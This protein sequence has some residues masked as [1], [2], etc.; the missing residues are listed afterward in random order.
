MAVKADLALKVMTPEEAK[1]Y[2][3]A[4]PQHSTKRGMHF[5]EASFWGL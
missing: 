3:I 2:R 5:E 1:K 4:K